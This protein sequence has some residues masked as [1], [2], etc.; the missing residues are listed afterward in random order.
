MLRYLAPLVLLVAC[1][2]SPAKP[3]T[4]RAELGVGF[5]LPVRGYAVKTSGIGGVYE[6]VIIDADTRAMNVIVDGPQDSD[7]TITLEPAQI[8]TLDALADKAWSEVQDGPMPQAHDILQQLYIVDHDDAFH[9]EASPIEAHERKTGRPYASDL[10][11]AIQKLAM[12]LAEPAP[13][14]A[15]KPVFR[16]THAIA[17]K[18]LVT[19][20]TDPALLPLHGVVAHAWGM[21]GDTLIA[22]DSDKSTVHVVSTIMSKKPV[23]KMFEAK[24]EKVDAVM[25]LALMAW[26]ENPTGEMPSATDIRE[27]LIVLDGDEAFYLSGHP[28][29]SHGME[30]GRP[31]ASEAITAIYKLA[32]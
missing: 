24:F 10:V 14:V 12:P 20:H 16:N 26:H 18:D 15:P 8:K 30:T 21:N 23:D 9:L 1:E 13:A 28:I 4:P 6:L 29:S 17:R 25:K 5:T 3:K 27:D 11:T 2:K 32:P 7:R 19:P 31:H 22:I